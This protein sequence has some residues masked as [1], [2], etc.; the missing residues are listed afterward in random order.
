MKTVNAGTR[1]RTTEKPD[2]APNSRMEAIARGVRARIDEK[3]GYSRKV[4]DETINIARS[5][6]VTDREIQA[7]INHRIKQLNTDEARLRHIKSLLE[8]I[9][10]DIFS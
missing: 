6:G 8:K 2:R 10:K 7:W 5:L 1:P 9:R 4:T 3:T